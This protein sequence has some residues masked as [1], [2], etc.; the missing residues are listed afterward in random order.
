M[1]QITLQ[2]YSQNRE[3][4][5]DQIIAAISDDE[6]FVAAWLTGSYSRAN[7]DALSD[8]DINIVVH[9]AYSELLCHRSAQV[10]AQ[11]T[12]ERM[13]L[14]TPFGEIAFYMKTIITRRMVALLQIRFMN[15]LH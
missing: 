1:T 10:S 4:I 11:T 7:I 6:R 12:P 14:F 9:E 5:L 2:T 8:I 3:L 15:K 13:E